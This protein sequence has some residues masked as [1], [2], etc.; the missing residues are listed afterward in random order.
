M[1]F[2]IESL[3][4]TAKNIFDEERKEKKINSNELKKIE[5]VLESLVKFLKINQIE[6]KIIQPVEAGGPSLIKGNVKIN[7]KE[8]DFL[9]LLTTGEW[10]IL[11]LK[12]YIQDVDIQKIIKFICYLEYNPTIDS[13]LKSSLEFVLYL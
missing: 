9:C 13:N 12:P 7:D 8:Y 10:R 6:Y 5:Q 11:T 3:I 1:F 2:N 4:A